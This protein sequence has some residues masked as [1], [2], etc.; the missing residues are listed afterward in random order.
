MFQNPVEHSEVSTGT[1]SG[2]TGVV[3][4]SYQII[5]LDPVVTDSLVDPST[6]L[7]GRPW[8][9]AKLRNQFH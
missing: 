1:I 7:F 3:L 4:R 5:V 9:S 2:I 8:G 6:Q